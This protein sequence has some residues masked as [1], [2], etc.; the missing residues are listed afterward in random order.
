MPAPAWSVFELAFLGKD[1]SG[2]GAANGTGGFWSIALALLYWD[3]P[4]SAGT[5]T[6]HE[7]QSFHVK[8]AAGEDANLSA[9]FL[10]RSALSLGLA[11]VDF[12]I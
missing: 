1:P 11:G 8:R 9:S 3:D 10:P 6:A 2:A 5:G 4:G 7:R 12:C